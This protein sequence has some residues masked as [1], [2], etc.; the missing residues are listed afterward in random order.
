MNSSCNPSCILDANS[1]SQ[2]Q[3]TA[4]TRL[5]ASL[6]NITVSRNS[7][8]IIGEF[9]RLL[10]TT[11]SKNDYVISLTQTMPMIWAMNHNTP[12]SHIGNVE[13]HQV[14][15][16]AFVNFGVSQPCGGSQSSNTAA[17]TYVSPNQ[18][19]TLQWS[20]N[21]NKTSITFM[22]QA[23]ATGW[24]GMGIG[25]TATMTST[26]IYVGWIEANGTVTFNDGWGTGHTVPLPDSSQGGTFD[27]HNITGSTV[28]KWENAGRSNVNKN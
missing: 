3:P 12:V 14:Q 15:G 9:Q 26:D 17:N 16:S 7:S 23:K 5:P 27:A 4:D 19:F 8:L 1:N 22:M 6:T 13:M 10:N 21:S 25:T 2:D 18:D 11:K 24:V 20:F 28:R